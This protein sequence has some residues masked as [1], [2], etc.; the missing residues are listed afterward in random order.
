MKRMYQLVPLVALSMTILAAG[1]SSSSSGSGSTAGANDGTPPAEAPSRPYNVMFDFNVDTKGMSLSDNEYIDFL[2][3]KTGV[4]IH[5]ESPG[6]SG[7]MDK[8]NITMASNDYPDAFMVTSVNRNKLLQFANDDLLVDLRPYLDRYPNFKQIPAEAWLPVTGENGEIWGIPYH[9]HDA[10]NQ[11]VYINKTWLDALELDIPQ[12]IDEFYDV[13]VAFTEQ[14]PDG[15]DR[16]D[17]YGLVG[18][19]DLSYGGRLFKAAFD[20]ETY[21]VIDGEVIPPAISEQYKEYLK[22]MNKLVQNKVFDPEWATS[23]SSVFREKVG[24]MQYGMFNGF[25]HFATNREFAP[26]TFNHFIT[27]DPPLRPDGSATTFAYDSVNR[28]YMGITRSAENVE[29]LLSFFDWVLSPEGTAYVYLGIENEHYTKD[30][31]GNVQLTDKEL[32]PLHWAFSMIKH[33]QLDDE[34]KSYLGTNYEP[35]VL[36]NLYKATDTGVLDEI[37]TALPYNPD[38]A[39]YN[40]DA[41]VEEYTAKSMFGSED[42]DATWDDYVKRYRASGGDKA[43]AFWTEWY[44]NR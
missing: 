15:N 1:C 18:N 3:E 5:L 31:S 43:I 39:A 34:V 30:G 4:R 26:D 36:E 27:I 11:V 7:Y 24:T 20:A 16:N 29:K 41:I 6:S 33:G 44:N 9:R 8:L 14:D 17:T 28:H 21:K 38:L 10:F 19:N 22:F 13:L 37:A 23:N 12:T 2:E 40:L 32:Q 35:E 42:I 25:W